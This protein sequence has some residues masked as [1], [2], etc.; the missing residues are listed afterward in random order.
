MFRHR[1]S[2]FSSL[3]FLNHLRFFLSQNANPNPPRKHWRPNISAILLLYLLRYLYLPYFLSLWNLLFKIFISLWQLHS[4]NYWQDWLQIITLFVIISRLFINQ[5]KKCFPQP[6]DPIYYV[7]VQ[8]FKS[9]YCL[10]NWFKLTRQKV[11][12]YFE[13]KRTHKIHF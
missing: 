5:L 9:L 12:S 13:L 3:C 4:F 10:W 2:S 7:I 8:T 6:S 1:E 11:P